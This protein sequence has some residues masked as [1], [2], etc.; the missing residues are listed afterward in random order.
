MTLRLLYS[1]FNIPLDRWGGQEFKQVGVGTFT[2]GGW[3]PRIINK[4]EIDIPFKSLAGAYFEFDFP[5]PHPVQHFEL[6]WQT[7]KQLISVKRSIHFATDRDNKVWPTPQ[8][9]YIPF[10]PLYSESILRRLRLDFIACE[11]CTLQLKKMRLVGISEAHKYQSFIP[12]RIQ[13]VNTEHFPVDRLK[14]NLK[15][16]LSHDKAFFALYALMVLAIMLG[17][18]II[19]FRPNKFFT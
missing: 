10:K 6:F 18:C 4:D 15:H 19:L 13:Y 7:N 5:N 12:P 3:D 17:I 14:E 2:A 8:R 9:I 16:K 11:E 1:G